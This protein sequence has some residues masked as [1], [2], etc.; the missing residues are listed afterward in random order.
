MSYRPKLPAAEHAR[1]R[2]RRT[3]R[4]RQDQEGSLTESSALSVKA[5]QPQCDVDLDTGSGHRWRPLWRGSGGSRSRTTGAGGRCSRQAPMQLAPRVDEHPQ[6]KEGMAVAQ[7]SSGSVVHV[8]RRGR[9]P[10]AHWTALSRSSPRPCRERVHRRRTATR[11]APR[12][13]RTCGRC[14]CR[15]HPRR[16]GRSTG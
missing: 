1:A 4:T 9:A 14:G 3:R 11:P 2:H 16:R 5:G 10:L 6:R 8:A 13:A 15:C 7:W 12:R